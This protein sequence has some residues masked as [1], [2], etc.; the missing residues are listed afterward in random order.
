[1]QPEPRTFVAFSGPQRIA[2]GPLEDVALATKAWCERGGD[3]VLIF[4]DETGRQVDLDLRGS[5]AEALERLT[6]HPLFKAG[7][8]TDMRRSGPGRPKLGVVSRE[9]SLLPRHWDWLSDQPGGASAALRRL[10]D[11]RMKSSQSRDRARKAHDAASRF[12][13][14]MAGN[15]P[16]FEEA[17]RALTRKHYDR[18][19]AL[20]SGWPADIRDHFRGLVSRVVDAEREADREGVTLTRG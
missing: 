2:A 13:W 20:I 6:Q 10:V 16:H 1:M 7:A 5:D 12:A 19:D 17:S 11:E 18:L 8:D 3:S 4:D 14:A 15:Y 9:V